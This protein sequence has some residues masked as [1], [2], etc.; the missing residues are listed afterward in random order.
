[1]FEVT[2][3]MVMLMKMLVTMTTMT[4]LMVIMATMMTMAMVM[5]IMATTMPMVMLTM[6]MV[7]KNAICRSAELH[8]ADFLFN[9]HGSVPSQHNGDFTYQNLFVI[10]KNM[11]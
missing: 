3:T 9:H 2:T 6:I 4:M 8:I 5:V 10:I 7:T 11:E 1:M